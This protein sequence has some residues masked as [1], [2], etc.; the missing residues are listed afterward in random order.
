[1]PQPLSL[2]TALFLGLMLL[3]SSLV[4]AQAPAP[5]ALPFFMREGKISTVDLAAGTLTVKDLRYHLSPTVRVYTYDRSMKDP[6]ALRADSRLQDSRV[7]RAGMRIGYTVTGEGGGKRGEVTEIWLLP[8]GNLPELDRGMR[9][10][11]QPATKTTGQA[12]RVQPSR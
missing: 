10:T 11:E 12:Q 4:L 3:L 2:S 6:Q 7:L 1:M 8:A 9:S 5:L